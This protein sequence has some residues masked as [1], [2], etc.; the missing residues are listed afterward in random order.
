MKLVGATDW[1][2]R[3]PFML[4]GIILGL[5]GAGVALATVSFGYSRLV[6]Y[7]RTEVLFFP[8][9]PANEILPGLT[10]TLLLLGTALGAIGSIVSV[11]RFLKI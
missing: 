1:Y 7:L 10:V 8:V 2:I 5:V 9:L 6:F 4:E 3:R 11:R